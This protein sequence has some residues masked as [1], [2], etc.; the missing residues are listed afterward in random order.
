MNTAVSGWLSSSG[1]SSYDYFSTG[2]KDSGVTPKINLSYQVDKDLMV[3]GTASQGFRPGGGNQPIPVT[4][5]LGGGPTGCLANL[6]AI[7]LTSAPP[8]FKPD[9]VWSY[10]LGEKFRDSDG[11]VTVNSAAYFENWQHI[12]QNIPLSCG[13]P[14]TGNAGDA[15]IYG[16][17][18]EVN[19]VVFPGL[20]ATVN[21]SWTHAQYIANAVPGTTIDERVQDVPEVTASASL[22][23]RHPISDSLGFIGR[24]DNDYVGS[25]I[26]T[27][28]Q[29]NY[30][31]AYDLTNIRAGVEA[32]HW[33]AL[34]FVDNATNR[35]ALLTNSPA[36]NVNVG[37]FNRTAMSQPLTFG[38]DL[39]YHLGGK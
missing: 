29:A 32:S 14:F 27:T 35:V 10:E 28:A 1:N 7:G 30:L 22:A 21:G 20:I 19:A 6:E 26:D 31:P 4:G 39:T 24:L 33:S 38:I 9:K 3:Y 15:H 23:Y 8:G 13:F 25:R 5:A 34:F 17:E 12:Q 18:L 11:R 36:I 2:E 16:A 37:T